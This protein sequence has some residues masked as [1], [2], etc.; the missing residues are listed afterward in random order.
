MDSTLHVRLLSL[1][2]YSLSLLAVPLSLL[3]LSR[4]SRKP[5]IGET[6]IMLLSWLDGS[7]S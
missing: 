2:V 5:L 4:Y 6:D 1:H 3:G 7:D